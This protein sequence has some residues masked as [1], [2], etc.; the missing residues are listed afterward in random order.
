M[1]RRTFLADKEALELVRSLTYAIPEE[2]EKKG[3]FDLARV[4]SDRGGPESS[5]TRDRKR[6]P[7]RRRY[8]A[9]GP[10]R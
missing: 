8:P 9:S 7:G 1:H 5:P 3:L 4:L 6:R 10:T 2:P